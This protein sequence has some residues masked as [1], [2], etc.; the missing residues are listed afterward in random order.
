MQSRQGRSLL[1]GGAGSEGIF[2]SPGAAD[3][4]DRSMRP[5]SV[6]WSE[7]KSPAPLNPEGAGVRG[8]FGPRSTC[9]ATRNNANHAKG[10][11]PGFYAFRVVSPLHGALETHPTVNQAALCRGGSVT[12]PLAPLPRLAQ[13]NG[14]GWEGAGV[15][16]SFGPRSTCSATRNNANHAKGCRPGFCAFRVVSRCALLSALRDPNLPHCHQA[17]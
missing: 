9:G 2:P 10:C 6:A 17:D 1:G 12:R 16:G 7:V 11:R 3:R 8:S 13:P 4:A 5:S 15:R 14:G